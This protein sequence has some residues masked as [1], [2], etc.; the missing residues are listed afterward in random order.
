MSYKVNNGP[1]FSGL[2]MAGEGFS[3][4]EN[5]RNS[6][7][8]LMKDRRTLG[9]QPL[10]DSDYFATL[11]LESTELLYQKRLHAMLELAKHKENENEKAAE[12][13]RKEAAK[14]SF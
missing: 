3:V 11:P 8:P 12:I 10:T 7:D 14:V 13:A 6:E 4:F 2:T 1:N 9:K 5:I